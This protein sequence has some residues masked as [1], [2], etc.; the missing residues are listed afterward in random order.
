MISVLITEFRDS[1]QNPQNSAE[2]PQK[3]HLCVICFKCL[4]E[5]VLHGGFSVTHGKCLV[6]IIFGTLAKCEDFDKGAKSISDANS[7]CA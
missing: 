2:N 5:C 6:C 1:K 4:F 7:G 3:S